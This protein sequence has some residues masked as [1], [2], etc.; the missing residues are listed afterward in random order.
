MEWGQVSPREI[1]SFIRF[2]IFQIIVFPNSL[3][4]G[5]K[6][7]LSKF[8][9]D[10]TN[11]ELFSSK[12]LCFHKTKQWKAFYCQSIERSFSLLILCFYKTEALLFL[13]KREYL[14]KKWSSKKKDFLLIKNLLFGK[15]FKVTKPLFSKLVISDFSTIEKH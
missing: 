15:N 1:Q 9:K 7:F 2:L 3:N 11:K 13:K 10:W 12:D 4:L 5:L 6:G 8:R 14:I